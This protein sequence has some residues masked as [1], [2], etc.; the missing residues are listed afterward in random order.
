MRD[1]FSCPKCG[2]TFSLS[3]PA[4]SCTLRLEDNQNPK[5]CQNIA[6]YGLAISCPETMPERDALMQRRAAGVIG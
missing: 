4:L 2:L 6:E 5:T 3:G 1:T